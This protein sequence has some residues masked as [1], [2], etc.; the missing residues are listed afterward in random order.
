MNANFWKSKLAKEM[1]IVNNGLSERSQFIILS[2][3]IICIANNYNLGELS[4][5]MKI[6]PII[7]S[8]RYSEMAHKVTTIDTYLFNYLPEHL[9]KSKDFIIELMEDGLQVIDEEFMRENRELFYDRDFVMKLTD[10]NHNKS[11]KY[12]IKLL[13]SLYAFDKEFILKL[14]D[15]KES[16]VG[17]PLEIRENEKF[18]QLVS[19]KHGL[20]CPDDGIPYRS[21]LDAEEIERYGAEVVNSIL[22]ECRTEEKEFKAKR[23]ENLKEILKAK[24]EREERI[25]KK[26]ENLR[27]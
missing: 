24:Q 4:K 21:Y 11:L 9:T 23:A 14:V 16:C 7:E 17:L 25:R 12:L 27:K 20:G 6:G 2:K 26:K 5:E 18:K 22:M 8:I 10:F 1:K 3:R 19:L 15:D 13:P